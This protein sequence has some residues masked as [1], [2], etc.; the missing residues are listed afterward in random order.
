M[1]NKAI[2]M[3]ALLLIGNGSVAVAAEDLDG[4]APLLCAATSTAVCE[5]HN[6][7]V[8]GPP[9]AVNLPVFW[10]VD[11]VNKTV[12]SKRQDGEQRS[13]SVVTVAADE[14]TL[15]LQ[16]FEKGLGWS[17][18][19]NRASGKMILTGGR[20]AGYVVFGNCTTL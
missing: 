10:R 17:V 4:S 3:A 14:S 8:Q 11:P 13:S 12:Q 6:D 1:V 2:G 5:Q 16:G 15:V 19:I 20:D 18:S 7:C 9:E